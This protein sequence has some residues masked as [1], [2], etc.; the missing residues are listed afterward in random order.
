MAGP[1]DYT[2]EQPNIAGSILGGIQAGQ[3]LGAQREAQDQ[4]RQYS[5]DLQTYLANPSAKG[6][7]EL[8][9][10][11]PKQREAYKQSWDILSKENQDQQFSSGTQAYSAIQNGKPEVALGILDKQIAA[12]ENSG[13]DPEN[14]VR[15]KEAVQQDPKSAG[16]SLALT[17]SSLEPE[18]WN[19]IATELRSSELAPAIAQKAGAEAEEASYK[20]SNTPERLTLENSK[21]RGE[22]RNID[23]QIGE[24]SQRLNLDRDRLQTDVELKLN[25]LGQKATTL[26]DGAKK[27]IND[28][29][30]NSVVA[31]QTAASMLDLAG[32]LEKEGGGYGAFTSASEFLKKATGNQDALTDMR[33]EYIRL[34]NTQAIKSLPPGPATDKDISLAMEGFPDPS[35]DAGTLASFIKGMAKLNQIAAVGENAKSE[36]VNSVG[37]LGK[38]KTDIEIDGVQVPAGTTFADFSKN[39]VGQKSEQRAA[40]Q[41]QQN[42][43]KRSYMK[44]ANP[45][46]GQ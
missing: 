22:L 45:A 35:A 8:S 40:Q 4:A 15:I 17:L 18:R 21:T 14:L 44:Y 20:A 2:I 10:K 46:G 29:A 12:M 39:Y 13:Q 27:L 6:A 9:V 7:S 42:V 30:V 36:W 5:T 11:Y 26:D 31:D 24:R 37:H 32:R 43:P 1:F 25:E 23:S 34:R 41:S 3:A 38:P 28:A 19:K 33:K 16:A